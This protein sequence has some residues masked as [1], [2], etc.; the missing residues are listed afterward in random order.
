MVSPLENLPVLLSKSFDQAQTTTANHQKNLVAL[1][2]LHTEAATVREKVQNGMSE[3]LT[4]ERAFEDAFLNMISR[5]LPVKK[6]ASVADRIVKF[7]GNYVKFIVEKDVDERKERPTDEE[8]EDTTAS[9]F[10]TR[11]LR[12]LLKGCVAKDKNVRYRVLQI[13]AEMISHLGQI[14]EDLFE[15]LRSILLERLRDKESVVRVQAAI[16]LCKISVAD[17]PDASPSIAHLLID[18]LQ[19]DTSPDVRRA[20]LVTIPPGGNTTEAILTRTRDVDATVRRSVYGV[21]L[22]PDAPGKDDAKPENNIGATHPRTLTISQRELIVR[23]GLGDREEM[24]KA[25]ATKLL[26]SWMD[27]VREHEDDPKDVEDES[28]VTAF[29][30]LFDLFQTSVPEDALLCVFAAR[31][32]VLDSLEFPPSFWEKLTPEKAFLIRVF[33]DHCVAAK[34]DARLESALP[35][36]GVVAGM[37]GLVYNNLQKALEEDAEEFMLREGMDD[38]DFEEEKAKRE[39]EHFDSECVISEMLKLALNLDY[40]DEIGRRAMFQLTREMISRQSLPESLVA[41]CLDVLRKLSPSERDLIRVVVEVVH[42]L[43]DPG[44]EDDLIKDG[45][46]DGATNFG[47][48][49]ATVKTVRA[50]PKPTSEM[51]PEEKARTDAIDLRCLSLC[52]GM[53]ER[54]NSRFEENSTLEGI[55][56]EL[57][58]PAVKRKE[59]SLR[60]K[61]LVALGLCCLIAR[62]MALNSFQLFL[63]QVQSAPD[64]LK[65]RVLQ[66]VFD[67]LMVNEGDFLGAGSTNG[68]RIV[69]FLLHILENEESEKVQALLCVG[70]S[71]LMLS[72][73][74][75]DDRVLRSLVLVYMSPETTENQELR[76]C[77]TYFFPVYCYS[78]PINQRRMQR[79]FVEVFTQLCQIHKD[80]DEDE[81]VLTPLQAGLMF[82]DWTDPQK[83]S[84][85]V[86]QIPGQDVD[87]VIHVELASEIMKTL[88]SDELTKNEKKSLCQLLGKIYLPDV[89]DDDKVRTL[90]LLIHN[91]RARRPLRD[92]TSKNA[93]NKFE[94]T[95]TKKFEKQL[96]AFDEAEYRELEHLKGLFE[97]LDDIIPISDD[98]EVEPP[99]KRGTRKSAFS[100]DEKSSTGSRPRTSKGKSKAKAVNAKKA[101]TKSMKPPDSSTDDEGDDDADDDEGEMTPPPRRASGSKRATRPSS[102]STKSRAGRNGDGMD[103]SVIGDVSHDSIMDTSFEE[104]DEDADEVDEIL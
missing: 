3:K 16:S 1:Y 27:I 12:F 59:L 66:I 25:A 30:R 40:G 10:N 77:L 99:K 60:E 78:S 98:E 68:E 20:V 36:V 41:R 26:T 17:D 64:V 80:W 48:T 8:E 87:D 29:L 5:I 91:V 97:F 37:I 2:K 52:I 4:G 24:V 100:C 103:S 63:S 61:G 101:V 58:V 104:E 102:T 11:L 83:A 74:I 65:L 94:A 90:K 9:R 50:L 38:P 39:D 47:E 93:F 32:D 57:I 44:E 72:G 88:F 18:S 21:A 35:V 56:G 53:L 49:P 82:V 69:E 84:I 62:R 15:L 51:S 81:D 89:V 96:E 54:V 76:Q 71:K 45:A 46:D 14:D 75:T 33:T 28:N 67:I 19:Y 86:K 92:V 22:N 13:V 43:R 55:L 6:G 31:P 42:E 79:I 73:M 85:V 23:N 7:T 95:L 70:I 34:D